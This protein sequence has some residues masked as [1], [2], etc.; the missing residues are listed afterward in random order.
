MQPRRQV[1]IEVSGTLSVETSASG[2]ARGVF[3]S[4]D[5][6]RHAAGKMLKKA[7]VRDAVLSIVF[8]DG[9]AMRRL[10]RESLGHDY[11]TDVITFNLLDE[12][13]A[14]RGKGKKN[15][16][17]EGEI[18]ICPAE[19]R[20]NARSYGE[21]L[22]REILRYVA[23]GILHLLGRDD[24]TNAQRERMRLLENELLTFSS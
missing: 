5:N 9:R 17:V 16:A 22:E 14:A 19:A 13:R 23:H 15:I 3:L 8:L 2:I 21:P 7:G 4:A 6:V 18:Y 20:R 11:V 10:N 24:R 1:H 12:K